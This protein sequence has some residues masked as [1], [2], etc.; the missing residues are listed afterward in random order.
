MLFT[1]GNQTRRVEKALSLDADAVI[2]DLEDAVANAEK[3]GARNTVADLTAKSRDAGPRLYV[4]INAHD[5]PWH[6]EDLQAV[7]GPGLD[8]IVLPKTE[9]PSDLARVD[10]FIGELETAGNLPSGTVDLLPIIETGAGL[11]AVRTIAGDGA[12]VRRLSFGAADFAVDM[13]M[14]WTR[15]EA[16]MTPARAEIALASRAAG[17]LAPIDSVWPRLG[18]TEG[19]SESAGRVRDLG[20]QGKFCIH[21]EQIDFVHAAFTPTEEEVAF[22]EKVVAA[23]EAAEA[24]GLASIAVDGHFVDYP[25]VERARRTVAFM[26]QLRGRG[27]K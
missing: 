19:L 12:R 27:P 14:R 18:D 26:D 11:A 5:T 17:L 9:N 21:P 23:F 16:E 2:L 22:A 8:G 20:F 13:G 15:G 4:R 10:A 7:V 25:I 24:D 1:P 6:R 3:P